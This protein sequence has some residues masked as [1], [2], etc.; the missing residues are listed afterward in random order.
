MVMKLIIDVDTGTD[1]A[2]AIMVAL[3]Q[4]DVEVLAITCVHGNVRV[5]EGCRNTLRVLQTCDRLDIPVYKGAAKPLV[6]KSHPLTHY[7]GLDGLG[8][9]SIDSASPVDISIIKEEF[10]AVA[11]VNLVNKYP[12]EVTL[13]AL[14]PLTNLSLAQHL[15]PEFGKKLKS[16]LIMGGNI[17]G[18]GR[19][20]PCAE[21][22]FFCDP[23]S[24]YNTLNEIGRQTSCRILAYEVALE[25]RL[26]WEWFDRWTSTD[27]KK[28]KFVKAFLKS[29]A[30]RQRDEL[31]LGGFRCCDPQAIACLF[32]D[33]C[34]LESKKCYC[35]VELNGSLT[36]GQMV[37]D[38]NGV[39]GQEPNTEIIS[40]INCD[41]LKNGF[42]AAIK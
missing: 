14:A 11:M 21:H 32:Y 24:A 7:H 34:V 42:E 38:W 19:V 9:T 27:T 36:R 35:T 3:A 15:D 8:D 2:L 13:V 33:G 30:T 29:D 12:G 17:T 22:N 6:M 18:K 31:K 16:L 25:H 28:A 5:N 41:L 4:S 26:S 20:T 23:E 1:D 10:A 37:V 40:K 39:L